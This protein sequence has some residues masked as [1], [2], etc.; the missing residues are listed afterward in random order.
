MTSAR[1]DLVD[2][3]MPGF[4]H[5]VSR[6]VRRA[7]LCGVDDYTG[8]SFAHRRQWIEDRIVELGERF[9]LGV[10]A[11]AVM[12]NHLH[13]VVRLDP[14]LAWSWSPE[15][16][17]RRWTA[18]FP[19]RVAGEIDEQA[20]TRR[21]AAIA[22]DPVRLACYPERLSSLSWVTRRLGSCEC[23][24]M[25]RSCPIFGCRPPIFGCRPPIDS[26]C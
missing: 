15:E 5:C 16:V 4:Y 26:R 11:Y 8:E 24:T 9:A 10:Y 12:S 23:S 20:T 17:A 22:G 19:V 7:W 25:Q 6:C 18:V 1:S 3:T 2:P 13:V 14:A 21:A